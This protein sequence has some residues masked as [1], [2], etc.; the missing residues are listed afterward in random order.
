MPAV[1]SDA[2]HRRS[3]CAS[4]GLILQCGIDSSPSLVCLLPRFRRSARTLLA[5]SF[6]QRSW[7]PIEG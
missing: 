3:F 7:P 6:S 1:P 4:S 2:G 5:I